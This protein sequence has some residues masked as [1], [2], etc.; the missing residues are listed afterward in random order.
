LKILQVTPF[1]PPN[2]GGIA[3]HVFNLTK[4]ISKTGISVRVI[5]PK[6]IFGNLPNESG[7]YV[8]RISSLYLT[9]WPYPTL[10]SVSIPIDVGIKIRSI[11]GHGDF[12]IV[13]VHGHHYP[14]SWIAIDAANRKGIPVV[15]TLHGTYALNPFVKGG[16]S[17]I[18]KILNKIFFPKVLK[19][20]YAIVGL[21]DQITK[22]GIMISSNAV[23]YFT[24]PNGIDTQVFAKNLNSK[25]DY[26]KKYGI[27]S[28]AIVILFRGRFE[29]VKGILEFVD[30]IKLI[31]QEL[32]PKVEVVIVGGGTLEGKIR[33]NVG[34]INGIHILGWQKEE[35]IPELYIASDIFA[36]P[37]RFEALPITII[38]AMNA[39]LF[40]M[41]TDVGGVSDILSGYKRKTLL[42]ELTPEKIKQV[43]YD[44]IKDY[45]YNSDENNESIMYARTF[46]WNR[47]AIQITDMYEDILRMRVSTKSTGR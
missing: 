20:T 25:K 2:K 24:I 22:Y 27:N 32:A 12:D 31:V 15:L 44:T 40:I 11:I 14:I 30:A 3:S 43:L 4:Y 17:K 39:G 7:S 16:Q 33:N 10:R 45:S 19:R 9:G 41:Y 13:H 23:R 34:S 35:D 28:D 5:A 29:H 46:D 1:F 18:E 26:R 36:L 6:K 42:S 47:V 37:S 38:E 21:T 8:E